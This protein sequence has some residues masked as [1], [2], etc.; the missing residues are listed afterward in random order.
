MLIGKLRFQLVILNFVVDILVKGVIDWALPE[1][2]FYSEADRI[3]LVN[4]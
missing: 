3:L 1:R 2:E 4:Q